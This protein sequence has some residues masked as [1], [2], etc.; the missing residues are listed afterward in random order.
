VHKLNQG[1]KNMPTFEKAKQIATAVHEGKFDKGGSPFINHPIAVMKQMPVEDEIMKT[2]AI[3]HDVVEDSSNK[4]GF[5]CLRK[6]GFSDDIIKPLKH[7]TRGD[8]EI[9]W[10][11]IRRVADDDTAVEVKLADL[12]HNSDRSRI[13][14]PSPK[15]KALWDKYAKASKY[16]HE[17]KAFKANNGA[18]NLSVPPY[19][20]ILNRLLFGVIREDYTVFCETVV[21]VLENM[22][23]AA[24]SSAIVQGRAKNLNSFT[25]KC[26]RKAFKYKDEN[27]KAMTDLCGTRVVL[28]T[29]GQVEDFCELIEHH[30][31]IDSEN[32]E[33]TSL[34]LGDAEF[35]YL[36]NHYIVSIKPGFTNVLGVEIDTH[37]F[38]DMKAEIQVRTFAQHIWADTLHDRMYKSAVR[39]LKEHKREAAKLASMLVNS[40]FL[41]N[42]FV[43]DYDTFSLNQT[44]YMSVSKIEEELE[45]LEVMNFNETYIFTRFTNALKMAGYLRNL[46]RYK[47]VSSLLEPYIA[48]EEK[49]DLKLDVFNQVRLRFEYGLSLLT[50][51]NRKACGYID[52]AV[53]GLKKYY[54][55]PV[56][57]NEEK[58]LEARRLY[59]FILVTAG[60]LDHRKDR[61]E[62]ALRVDV[63]N[64]YACAG[65]LDHT[66]LSQSLLR[67]AVSAAREHLRAGINEPEV[68]FVLGRLWLAL[69]DKD[70]AF[71]HYAD[72]LLFYLAKA[73]AEN[74]ND[75]N[76]MAK[77]IR[78]KQILEREIKYLDG[79]GSEIAAAVS[80]LMNHIYS[81]IYENSESAPAKAVWVLSG[82]TVL[83]DAAIGHQIHNFSSSG[84]TARISEM[85]EAPGYLFLETEEDLLVKAALALG[86]KVI[87]TCSEMDKR[88]IADENIRKTLRYYTLPCE[89]ES[90]LALFA[91]RCS[92]LTPEQIETA[93][94]NGHE[95]Y[96]LSLIENMRKSRKTP[97]N[98]GER[99]ANWDSLS[100]K[101]KHSNTDK[102]EYA[103]FLFGQAGYELNKNPQDALV[104]DDIPDDMKLRLAK[105]EHGRWNAERVVVG[106]SYSPVRDDERLLHDNITFWD[107]L[108]P[109]VQGYDFDGIR[110]LIDDFKE[111]GL[112]LHKK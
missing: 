10:D 45:I 92:D 48:D 28:Q 26:V 62:Q 82:N 98:L 60:T 36:S 96:A 95:K 15:D 51:N 8:G 49:G 109:P 74:S 31:D 33:D 79:D 58:Q 77:N 46:G 43:V 110:N 23:K 94:R 66:T 72:G 112:F 100:Q 76:N 85:A 30:F 80:H 1:D 27:F 29:V 86:L 61:L 107:C 11:Y 21:S 99:T 17:V 20:Y 63:T 32:S 103:P 89:A 81:V 18:M 88:L 50:E 34:R 13:P 14:D 101:H 105:L 108:T 39:P 59:V 65:L 106:W 68:Y 90:F 9:Y 97:S 6:E 69:N 24:C 52:M 40:D 70:R 71:G 73:D 22:A 3:L 41:L 64:P 54:K 44:S 57:G 47:D 25:E 56:T 35:G 91:E 67:G 37:R 83:S 78:I 5:E 75:G 2:V 12:N 84:L 4:Y 53:K 111:L 42:R 55:L 102:A 16:L 19:K 7:L 38:K 104:W 93:A 87:S